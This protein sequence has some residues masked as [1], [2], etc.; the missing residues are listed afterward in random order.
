MRIIVLYA[1]VGDVEHEDD[2]ARPGGKIVVKY[3]SLVVEYLTACI[4]YV[5]LRVMLHVLKEIFFKFTCLL[6]YNIRIFVL[7]K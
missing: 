2:A 7:K 5:F 3:I 1:D 6:T 4:L